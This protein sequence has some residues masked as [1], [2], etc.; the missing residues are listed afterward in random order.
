MFEKLKQRLD[1]A[2]ASGGGLE[3]QALL[4]PAVV[5]TTPQRIEL[6]Q[7]LSGM[8]QRL[9][10]TLEPLGT[11]ALGVQAFPTFLF[12]RGIDPA[13]FIGELVDRAE[14]E[15]QTFT[16]ASGSTAEE[17][18]LHEVL[19]MMA[20]KAAIKAGDQLSQQELAELLALREEIERSSNCPH[21]RPTALR[22]TIKELERQFGRS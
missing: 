16:Q 11:S 21:G 22:L 5:P 15:P 17:A 13:E 6:V 10:I 14:A 18:A 1:E 7:S 8:L 9:G 19:D 20:C 4:V 3:S 2:R 12:E